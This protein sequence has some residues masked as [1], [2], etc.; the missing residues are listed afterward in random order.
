MAAGVACSN[1]KLN[2]NKEQLEGNKQTSTKSWGSSSDNDKNA[3][4]FTEQH[5]IHDV[6]M[7]S[8]EQDNNELG[9]S[10]IKHIVASGENDTNTTLTYKGNHESDPEYTV[11]Q[12]RQIT[13]KRD[14]TSPSD[15]E[16][17]PKRYYS[18]SSDNQDEDLIFIK[19]SN[20]NI[21]EKNPLKLKRALLEADPTLTPN[22]IK[23]TKYNIIIN[24]KNEEQKQKMLNLKQI[25]GTEVQTFE[26]IS[27]GR[28][29]PQNPASHR[30]IIFGVPVDISDDEIKLETSA[31]L[32]KRLEKRQDDLGQTRSPTT[33]VVLTFN[34]PNPERVT[35]G[36]M[37]FKTK[38]YIPPPIR[39][40][41]CQHFGHISTSCRSKIS[42]PRCSLPHEYKD[43]PTL[44]SNHNEQEIEINLKCPNCND[45]HSAGFRGC[46]AFIKAK[47]IA[48]IRATSSMSYSEALKAYSDKQTM[49]TNFTEV[50]NLIQIQQQNRIVSNTVGITNSSTQNR[51]LS[52]QLQTSSRVP[53]FSLFPTTHKLS[54]QE[55][56]SNNISRTSTP[57]KIS[58]TVNKQNA[59]LIQVGN[60]D[61]IDEQ[62]LSASDCDKLP[63]FSYP[64]AW[65]MEQAAASNKHLTNHELIL[66]A[67][68]LL[69]QSISS[70]L[71]QEESMIFRIID[72]LNK[73]RP[74]SEG[75]TEREFH[76]ND[77]RNQNSIE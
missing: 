31:V 33:T 24:A 59:P 75:Q 30:C 52:K 47:E 61:T 45:N 58:R 20:Y 55:S 69:I 36:W 12:R 71:I 26:K 44:L 4:F 32:V 49:N 29:M 41:K 66:N 40:F 70:T 68:I 43:C 64:D 15:A 17:N 53:T 18:Q 72:S 25:L 11:I 39:C 67:I 22:Q 8:T 5:S 6:S 37:S 2:E 62:Q 48:S 3:D 23:Y 34:N 50:P 57:S 1:V 13:N 14:R 76:D 56:A 27:G 28:L 21:T 60:T 19:G 46:P 38:L 10:D 35:I 65:H 54:L 77:N 16:N 73:L 74:S 7:G 51:N 42:C 9:I 63:A